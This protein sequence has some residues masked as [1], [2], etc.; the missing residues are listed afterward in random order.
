MF[1]YDTMPNQAFDYDKDGN[2]ID[3]DEEYVQHYC[4]GCGDEVYPEDGDGRFCELC[5][6]NMAFGTHFGPEGVWY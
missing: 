1:G 6:G 3:P 2:P 4:A 5:E